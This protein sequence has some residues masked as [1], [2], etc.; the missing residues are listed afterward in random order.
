MLKQS[1]AVEKSGLWIENLGV[2]KPYDNDIDDRLEN[3]ILA[4]ICEKQGNKP[5]ANIYLEK[6]ISRY[7]LKIR[8]TFNSNDYITALALR[9]TGNAKEADYLMNN[10]MGKQSDS[11][12]F[13]WCNAMYNNEEQKA[14]K[15]FSERYTIKEST[16]WEAVSNDYNFNVIVELLKVI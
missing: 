16:P 12:I 9:E 14:D 15:L 13:Q 6:I 4:C 1:E 10:W 3:Y 2:G 5:E 11:K 7:T 8:S